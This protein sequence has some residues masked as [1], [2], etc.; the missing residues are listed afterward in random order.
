LQN[1]FLILDASA[2]RLEGVLGHLSTSPTSCNSGFAQLPL[3]Q[4]QHKS[5]CAKPPHVMP[6]PKR[7]HEMR[8]K[9]IINDWI[10]FYD[11][12]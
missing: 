3:P 1:I 2:F 9:K 10:I 4:A 12:P 6:H 11:D 5:N 7:R 8:E